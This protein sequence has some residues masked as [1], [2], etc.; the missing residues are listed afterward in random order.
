M[1]SGDVEN[2][3]PMESPT[4]T[5]KPVLV[6]RGSAE[7]VIFMV[8]DDD[9]MRKGKSFWKDQGSLFV[10]IE[11]KRVVW[12]RFCVKMTLRSL[13]ERLFLLYP[14]TTLVTP[15]FNAN[16]MEKDLG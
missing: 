5:D 16:N 6:H 10:I 1:A 4:Q 13:K 11:M 7:D 2:N 12:I 15:I 9:D 3:V 14:D 8:Y